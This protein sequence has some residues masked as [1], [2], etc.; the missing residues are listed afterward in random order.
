MKKSKIN[1]ISL[2]FGSYFKKTLIRS[3]IDYYPFGQE[4]PGRVYSP[5]SYRYGF[6]GKENDNEVAGTGNW[7]NYGM[8]E[9][10]ARVCRFISVDPLT[11]KFPW[12]TP[13]QFAGNK[14]IIAVDLDGLEER[15]VI[16]T[17][18]KEGTTLVHS[19][20]WNDVFPDQKKGPLGN[21]TLTWIRNE[22]KEQQTREISRVGEFMYTYINETLNSVC[23]R[24]FTIDFK[25]ESI[26]EK[27]KNF[28]ETYLEGSSHAIPSSKYENTEQDWAVALGVVGTVISGGVL[29]EAGVSVSAIAGLLINMEQATT[30]KDGNTMPENFIEK[31]LGTDAKTTYK[32]G[33]LT[34]SAG[35]R[36]ANIIESGKKGFNFFQTLDIFHSSGS[37]PKDAIDVGKDIKKKK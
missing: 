28:E 18:T 2:L 14:P 21:G 22:Y 33:K 27:E 37:I 26:L 7:Q 8:R 13:Y 25:K 30:N 3:T 6:N 24:S 4:M 34:F 19:M 12:Y 15:I 31:N 35:S 29:A 17:N 10:D 23:G 20:N 16:R 1:L 11:A 32:I 5:T 36:T 9:Y